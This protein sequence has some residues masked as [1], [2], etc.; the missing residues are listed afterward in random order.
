MNYGKVLYIDLTRRDFWI[1]DRSELFE[2]RI[3]GTGVALE[4]LKENI[5]PKCDPLGP[6]NTIVFAVGL[7]TGYYP[8]ASKTVAMFKSPLTGNLGESHAG[9]R[10]AIAIRMAGYEAIVIKGMSDTPV[11]LVITDEGVRFRDASSLWGIRSTIT[12]ARIIREVEGGS[13]IRSIIRI[14]K[15]GERLVRYAC[16]TTETYRHFGRLGLGAVLGSK[17]LKAIVVYGKRTL[18]VNDVKLYRAVYDEIFKLAVE[19]ELMKKYHDLG[20]PINVKVLH[21]IGALPIMNLTRTSFKEIDKISG[22]HIA[23]SRLGRRVACSHCPVACIHL[24]I[25][26]EP[27]IDE[28]YFY[29][30]TYVSY[31]YEPIYAI[32]AMLGIK[33]TDG[34]LRLLDLV[35]TLGLDAISTGVVLSWATEA[36]KRGVITER[37]TLTELDWGH[38]EGYM[39]AINF[40]VEQPN[41]FYRDLGMGVEYAA[42]KYGGLDYALAFG[43]N[44]MPGYNTGPGAYL[45][46]LT[47]ARHSHLDSAGYSL[48][49]K[50]L[51][52]TLPSPEELIDMLM[53]EEAWRQVLSSLVI[54]FFARGIY[55]AEKV[56]SALKALGFNFTEEDLRN[57]GWEIYREKYRLKIELGFD[58]D[59]LRIPRRIFETETP[60]GKIS[61]EYLDR[62]LEYFKKKI[63]SMIS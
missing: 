38:V 18:P 56:S 12:V 57:L 23:R 24:A 21:K 55:S 59:K 5:D 47:G 60:H 27:Y 14:G 3:G 29:K 31:D 37:E 53:K 4:L 41:Q 28:P 15:A 20:T 63:E 30:T 40:I 2:R 34:L 17:K 1:E 33:D 32:G 48:D 6:G 9:G 46:Y 61:K 10:S 25:L 36:Y 49:Q 35:E 8:M 13:G 26:R 62:A 19:T 45:T 42:K 50:L 22:E 44:E 51:G 11:Y 54:C 58:L 52:K 7:L 39:K 16:A 43:G